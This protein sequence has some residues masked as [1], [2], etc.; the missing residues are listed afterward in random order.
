MAKKKDKGCLSY[1]LLWPFYMI[2]YCMKFM[3][4]FTWEMIKFPY[5]LIKELSKGSYKRKA[6]GVNGYDYEQ[7]IAEYLKASG[8]SSVSVTQYSGDYGVDVIAR[9]GSNKYAVQC[10]YYSTPVGVQAVQEVV[11]G[12]AHYNCNKAMV[13]TNNTFTDPAKRLAAENGVKL[14]QYIEIGHINRFSLLK[15]ILTFLFSLLMV[16]MIISIAY[17]GFSSIPKEN[18]PAYIAIIVIFSILIL[19]QAIPKIKA[20]IGLKKINKDL[21]EIEK[22]ISQLEKR[23]VRSPKSRAVK[24]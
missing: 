11:G 21:N 13:I 23:K 24:R 17:N 10:K 20:E 22:G 6:K 15:N 19:L 8:Y 4:L 14:K 1:L 12:M 2:W 5:N 7:F 3:L 18:I 16:G 9:K